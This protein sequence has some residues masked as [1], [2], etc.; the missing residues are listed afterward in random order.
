[1]AGPGDADHVPVAVYVRLAMAEER[2][3]SIRRP[4]LVQE[5]LDETE[6]LDGRSDQGQNPEERAA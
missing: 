6:F 1:M 5:V 2:W 4:K 3:R